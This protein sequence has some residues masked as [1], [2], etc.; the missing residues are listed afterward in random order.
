MSGASPWSTDSSLDVAGSSKSLSRRNSSA[1]RRVRCL[2]ASSTAPSTMRMIG[3]TDSIE[4]RRALAL[5]MRPPFL[6]FSRVSRA[7]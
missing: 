5:P 3:F 4:P 7:P 2:P 6:R 1:R